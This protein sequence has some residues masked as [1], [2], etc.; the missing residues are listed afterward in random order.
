M[1]V[2]IGTSGFKYDDW[3]P[4]FYPLGLKESEFLHYYGRRFPTVEINYTYY[5]MPSAKTLAT[6]VNRTKPD[7]KFSVKTHKSMT[8]DILEGSSLQNPGSDIKGVFEKFK[9]AL[10]PLI[11]SGKLGC[12]L[13]QFPWRFK[14]SKE[15]FDYIRV[16][17][18]MLE[19][20]P[21]V[22]EFRSN[23]WVKQETFDFLKRE[24]LGFCCVDEPR[25]KGLMPPVASVTSSIA[26]VRFHGRNKE[27]WYAHETVSERY[28][29]LYSEEELA[30]WVPKIRTMSQ[31][32][33]ETYIFFNNCHAG[34]APTNALMLMEML[35][36]SSVKEASDLSEGK[37]FFQCSTHG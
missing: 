33:K 27:K 22:I 29:Y 36:L 8:H 11:S 10:E 14:P 30:E 7:F 34:Y 13:A 3:R 2:L 16:V 37:G 24:G 23:W 20:L 12:V 28:D 6:L 18:D 32:A 9:G 19:G 31:Q 17:R 5:T 15:S 1:N 21:L 25:L 35:G 4:S 26:Y